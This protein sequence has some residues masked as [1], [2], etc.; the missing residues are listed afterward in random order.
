MFY[1]EENRFCKDD[2]E[3]RGPGEVIV[4]RPEGRGQR[5]KL[6]REC[7]KVDNGEFLGDDHGRDPKGDDRRAQD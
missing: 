3:E 6:G 5:G 1:D 2:T 7:N 4:G